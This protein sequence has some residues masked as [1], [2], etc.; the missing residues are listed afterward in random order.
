MWNNPDNK[1]FKITMESSD[2]GLRI[3]INKIHESI[4]YKKFID[5]EKIESG[6]QI[7]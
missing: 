7:K 5:I 6:I 4:S 3:F 1:Y 2:P